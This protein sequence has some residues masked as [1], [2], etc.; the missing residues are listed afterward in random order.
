[1]VSGTLQG[2][3]GQGSVLHPSFPLGY[4]NIP[5]LYLAIFFFFNVTNISAAGEEWTFITK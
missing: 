2:S 4:A 3:W 5:P 1:M